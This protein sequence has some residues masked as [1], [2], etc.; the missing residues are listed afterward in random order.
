VRTIVCIFLIQSKMTGND[1][2]KPINPK[3][4]ESN[5]KNR[6]KGTPGTNLQFDQAQSNRANQ[7]AQNRPPVA[8]PIPKAVPQL[9]AKPSPKP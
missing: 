3:D 6:N 9:V 5:Q 1:M 4:N 8:K 7:L 2:K